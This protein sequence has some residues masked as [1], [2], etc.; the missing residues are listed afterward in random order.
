MHITKLNYKFDHTDGAV[1]LLLRNVHIN[2]QLAYCYYCI[3]IFFLYMEVFDDSIV[4]AKA[5]GLRG[6]G[7]IC[8]RS[9]PR[10]EVFEAKAKSLKAKVKFVWGQG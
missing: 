3:L 5:T 10:P 2:L 4:K 7:Q 6:Q 9:R 1:F 8:S